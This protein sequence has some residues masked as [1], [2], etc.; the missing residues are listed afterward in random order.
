MFSVTCAMTAGRVEMSRKQS[1]AG[2]RCGRFIFR[3]K[4]RCMK[5]L[6]LFAT[7]WLNCS[8][9]YTRDSLAG[10]Y[11][12]RRIKGVAA[13]AGGLREVPPERQRW[14]RG[15]V[16]TPRPEPT[17]RRSARETLPR[18]R[19]PG[20]ATLAFSPPAGHVRAAGRPASG[21]FI[22]LRAPSLLARLVNVAAAP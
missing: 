19:C 5:P 11:E 18:R 10:G 12:K 2:R 1:P 8:N 7:G 3:R 17:C 4:S 20:G 16:R 9:C 22:A 21:S 15:S 13:V 14:S 6:K